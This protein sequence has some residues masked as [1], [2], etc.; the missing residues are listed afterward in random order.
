M[1]IPIRIFEPTSEGA[2]RFLAQTDKK[3]LIDGAWVAAASGA[4]FTTFDPA[5]GKSLAELAAA[6][7]AD[8]D[9]AVSSA[10][11]AFEGD[12]WRGMTP[13]A[14]GKLL[15]R[16]ADLIDAHV[17]ELAELETLDQGKSLK[18][19]RFGEIPASAEQFRYYAGFT[20]KILG[21]TIPTSIGYQP[22]GK[23][24]FAYTTREPIGV[25]AAI[26]PWNSPMLMAAMK[27]A[28]A[29]AA[30]CTVVLKPAE[31][32][33]L[34]TLRL[35]ELMLEAGLPRGVVNI[36]T[37][38]GET[39]GAALTAHPGVDKVAFTG[40][41]E[42]GKLIVGAARGNLKKLTLEL[43]GKSPAI[44]MPDADMMLA[45]PGIARGIFANGGQVC[46]AGSRVYA[47]RSIY[48]RLVEGLAQEAAKLRLGHGLD[49]DV[50]LGP[51]VD[52][53]QADHVA[54][55]VA[56]GAKEGAEIV[57]G[58]AQDGEL[59]TFYRPTVMTGVRQD[60][61]MMREEIF[62]PV[63]AVTPFDDADEAILFANDSPYGLAASVWTQDLS[64][65][66]RLSARIRSGTVWINCHSYF[67]PELPK[68]GHK[69]SGWGYEN[70][71]P[72]LENYLET[73]TVC[74]VV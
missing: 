8:I 15:W 68:G 43:G 52:R 57:T 46:V 50:D 33:S 40:S 10:R 58:G 26:T 42:V 13:S 51:L 61:R 54:R 36:V 39:V 45:I 7:A 67:S 2:R 9:A 23:K 71:A 44:V 35:A 64:S 65:A 41:T 17:D 12:A 59:K 21:T 6:G 32:T 20:T 66:H 16:I 55:Y 74:A 1:T 11:R 53:R 56:E 18:T 70:G 22:P 19:G 72:G 48:Q 69:Q 63:V 73:K 14:R 47:H 62:G 29:L 5:T 34:T 38:M 27:L 25:V 28:P 60:M 3:L 24:I 30:G 31:E 4:T 37:G 49:P